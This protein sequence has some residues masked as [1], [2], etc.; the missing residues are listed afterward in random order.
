MMRVRPPNWTSPEATAP[1]RRSTSAPLRLTILATPG[2]ARRA[3][4]YPVSVTPGHVQVR[5]T[6][7]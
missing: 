3:V 6:L 1:S 5:L 2:M 7:R 4:R